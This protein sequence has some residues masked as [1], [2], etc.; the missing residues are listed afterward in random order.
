MKTL[1]LGN[2]TITSTPNH[3]SFKSSSNYFR[4]PNAS[5][6]QVSIEDNWDYHYTSRI[7]SLKININS[8]PLT[9]SYTNNDIQTIKSQYNELISLLESY[10][11]PSIL[12]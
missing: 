3:T 2:Y 6:I 4:V 11:E 9:L 8:K 5:I 1:V 10:S 12:D 7:Y